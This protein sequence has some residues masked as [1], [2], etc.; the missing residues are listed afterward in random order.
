MNRIKDFLHFEIF[1][2]IEIEIIIIVILIFFTGL[3]IIR[4]I[5]FFLMK[6]FQR[7]MNQQTMMLVTKV[8]E[9]LGF[10]ILL[11]IILAEL[12]LK[13]STL[14][15]AAGIL[16]I[17][18]G[19]ASQ[20]SLGNIIS[21]IFLVTE[22]SFEIGD[23]IKVDDKAGVVY[24]IDLL[25]IMLKTFDNLLIRIP[26]E[27]LISTNITNVTK[28]PI[29][30]LDIQ[31]LVAYKEDLQHVLNTLKSLATENILCLDEPEPF[32]MVKEFSDSGIQIQFG[33]W[34]E[35]TRYVDTRNSMM[36]DIH[37]RFRDEKIEIPYTHIK[38]VNAD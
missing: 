34:F 9:Y 22:K 24:S 29:R 2:A 31:I 18:V 20:K 17:A 28:F 32:L 15:G 19:V 11:M 27:T 6:T 16:G 13:L 8:V 37:N 23:V 26:N 1:G 21:G 38:I 35:K 25:S 4:F 33:L 3:F 5:K 7:N 10:S 14:L 30:R 12:G 36:I